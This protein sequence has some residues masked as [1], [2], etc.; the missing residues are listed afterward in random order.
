MSNKID[1]ITRE[2]IFNKPIDRVWQAISSSEEVA[3]W[4]GSS[5][6]FELIEGSLGYF[7]WEEE[8]E[9]RF[10]IR[11]ESI[12]EPH[13]FA[14]RWMHNQDVRFDEEVAT[15]V[16]WQLTSLDEGKTKLVLT[17]SGFA[18]L[19]HRSQNVDGW[20]QELDDLERYLA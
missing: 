16:E 9:G 17:E 13:Y 19:K 2:L 7:E 8:C 18:E 20:T 12:K 11:I 5:A 1:T 15:L 3:L 14:W 10:A 6:S 4:F